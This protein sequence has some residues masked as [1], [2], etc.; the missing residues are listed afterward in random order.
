MNLNEKIAE[1]QKEITKL[2]Y[3]VQNFMDDN[4]IEFTSKLTK[5]QHLVLKGEKIFEELNELQKRIDDQ[6]PCEKFLN[7]KY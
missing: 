3:D 2:K 5:D 7:A 6:V 4:Y 1:I